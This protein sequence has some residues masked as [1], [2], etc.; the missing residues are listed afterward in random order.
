MRILTLFM[1]LFLAV[2]M[3][4]HMVCITMVFLVQEHLSPQNHSS[5][6]YSPNNNPNMFSL[7][8][9]FSLVNGLSPNSDMNTY[10]IY[11][12]QEGR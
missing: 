9:K 8:M 7:M 6:S 11:D 5:C 3:I 4:M 12:R 2:F 10:M 1:S